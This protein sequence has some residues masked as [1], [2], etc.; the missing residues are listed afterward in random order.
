MTFN[1]IAL[2]RQALPN[3]LINVINTLINEINANFQA[4]GFIFPGAVTRRQFFSALAASNLMPTVVAGIPGNTNDPIYIQFISGLS[5]TP[6]D[7]LATNVQTTLG[8]T[9]V[10]MTA[11][12]ALASSLTP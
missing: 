9:A 12:F 2:F 4:V 5:V 6:G 8:Y 11:I 1:P 3:D 7:T 10:Q